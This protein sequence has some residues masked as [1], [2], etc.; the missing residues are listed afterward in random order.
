MVAGFRDELLK[1]NSLNITKKALTALKSIL[2]EMQEQE[3]VAQNVAV[4][5]QDQ[6]EQNHQPGR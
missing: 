4:A 3:S 6:K 2:A 1:Q 5:C